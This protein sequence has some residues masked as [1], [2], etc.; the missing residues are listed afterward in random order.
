MM[1]AGQALRPDLMLAFLVWVGIVGFA[2][3]ALLLRRARCS[4]AREKAA[5]MRTLGWRLGEFRSCSPL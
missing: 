5:S 4:A 3:N 2:L 1:P